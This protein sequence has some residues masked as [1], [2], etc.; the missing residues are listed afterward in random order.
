MFQLLLSKKYVNVSE[1]Q[2]TTRIHIQTYFSSNGDAP[3]SGELIPTK[4]GIALTT[5]EWNALKNYI[6]IVD[7][8]IACCE[9]QQILGKGMN[10]AP[11]VPPPN[12]PLSLIPEEYQTKPSFTV[13]RPPLPKLRHVAPQTRCELE[14][15]DQ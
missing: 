6:D 14:P 2:G 11:Y 3:G 7:V 15:F 10:H 8:E 5:D 9:D 12:T 4:K 13:S 1:W